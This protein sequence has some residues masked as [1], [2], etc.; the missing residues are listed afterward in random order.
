MSS[1]PPLRASRVP[2]G[3]VERLVR[4]GWMASNLAA[5]A[6]VQSAR[7]WWAG[8]AGSVGDALLSGAN[9]A[10][11]AKQL[12][13]KRGAAMKLGQLLS[14]EGAQ[15]LPPE[16]ADALALLRS[17]G[18][19]MTRAQLHGVLGREYGKGWQARFR[20]F[21]ETPV[22]AASIGQVHRAIAADGRDLALK[23]Q[24][25][26][27]ARSIGSDVD[28]LGTL[29]RMARLV[30]D[31]FD[32]RPILAEV[33]RQLEQETDYE[34][35]ARA[36]NRYR[37]LIADEPHVRAPRAHADLTTRHVLAMDYVDARPVSVLWTEDHPQERRDRIATLA[38]RL[39]LRELFDLRLMQSDPNFANFLWDPADDGLVLLDFGSTVEI[40]A[41]LSERYRR[42]LRASLAG[43]RDGI[44][45]LV[46]EFG[47]VPGDEPRDRLEGL[48][49]VILLSTEPLRAPGLY[50]YGT[51]DLAQ[52]T[53]DASMELAFERGL[54]LPPPPE[55][56]F[57][58][59]KLGG[60]YLLCTSLR[61]RIASGDLARTF[62]G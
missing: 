40:P 29:V 60:T 8:E 43:D 30:P 38:Q 23:I 56:L 45:R 15:L 10:Q 18:D 16:F 52:R 51:S 14:L 59:R 58:N 26:G 21:D 12:S 32:L 39:V 44:V 36:L 13:R 4:F 5:N 7:R 48:A 54:L 49:D 62:L 28:N 3:R 11:L 34:A 41:A 25:P 42:L 35:E 1:S 22:A 47:W 33:K 31:G 24:Y 61:A 9:A 20:R 27:V 6:A 46:V 2:A 57:V 50:D 53:H 17:S 19:T 37:G 55:L